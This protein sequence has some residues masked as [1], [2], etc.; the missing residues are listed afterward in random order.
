MTFWERDGAHGA[1]RAHRAHG[2]L[3]V[4]GSAAA[5]IDKPQLRPT[6]TDPRDR[7]QAKG[8]NCTTREV[9]IQT[10]GKQINLSTV[11]AGVHSVLGN[12]LSL[13]RDGKHQVRNTGPLCGERTG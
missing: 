3:R 2:V 7:I 8:V 5:K 4:L 9:C 11:C 12:V 13:H 6:R 1:R 10:S